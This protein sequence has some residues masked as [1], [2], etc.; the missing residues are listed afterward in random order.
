MRILFAAAWLTLLAACATA[1]GTAYAPADSKGY[2]YTDVRVESDRYRITFAGDGAT[3]PDAV[4]DM[5]LL[6]AADLAL[7][8]GYDWFRV[9][10]RSMD[11]Q[12]KGGVGL[13]MG[14]GT[15]SYGRRSS[16]GVGV[17]GDLGTIG[18]KKFY[19]TRIEVLMGKGEKPEG[20]GVFDARSVSESVRAR[21]GA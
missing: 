2:G 15:G 16:V 12:E 9:T 7:A 5:A 11:A 8:N 20:D 21:I 10:G 17:G 3:P 18:A 6:R 14:L 1:V 4:E 19:T 13:G